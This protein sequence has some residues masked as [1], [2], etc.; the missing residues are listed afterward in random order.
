MLNA[1]RTLKTYIGIGILVF[2][3]SGL[4]VL[5]IS[6]S[7]LLIGVLLFLWYVVEEVLSYRKKE[8]RN[9]FRTYS[10]IILGFVASFFIIKFI[11]THQLD[12]KASILSFFTLVLIAI[13]VLLGF[14]KVV[15]RMQRFS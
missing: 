4:E 10:D 5:T 9:N 8:K 6:F 13:H 11:N 12:L 14:T 15:K 1:L 2:Y 3:Y 7:V